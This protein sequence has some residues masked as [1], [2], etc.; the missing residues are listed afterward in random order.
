MNL[1][2]HYVHFGEEETESQKS[3]TACPRS[4]SQ[5]V[6]LLYL[7]PASWMPE[8]QF[9]STAIRSAAFQLSERPNLLCGCRSQLGDDTCT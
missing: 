9:L 1:S 8:P 6:K 3:Y 5:Q 2:H 4:P 7:N